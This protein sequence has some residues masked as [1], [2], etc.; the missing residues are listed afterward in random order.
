MQA[1]G[2]QVSPPPFKERA[3]ENVESTWLERIISVGF[4]ALF[5]LLLFVLVFL[6]S[7]QVCAWLEKGSWLTFANRQ[8]SQ[9]L[10]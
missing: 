8:L 5:S 1:I 4:S 10:N 3:H 6:L 2:P 9:C 7:N